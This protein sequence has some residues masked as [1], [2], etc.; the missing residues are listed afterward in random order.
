MRPELRIVRREASI[1]S[2]NV[3]DVCSDN[4]E[5]PYYEDKLGCA[6]GVVFALTFQL[7][8][9][10]ARRSLLEVPSALEPFL[11][12]PANIRAPAMDGTIKQQ[13]SPLLGRFDHLLHNLSIDHPPIVFRNP[14][15]R[16]KTQAAIKLLR[17]RI[18]LRHF[19]TQ[20]AC[21]LLPHLFFPGL[22]QQ[23]AQATAPLLR[24][25]VESDDM[26]CAAS[27][28]LGALKNNEARQLIAGLLRDPAGTL[29][30]GQE[31]LQ[32]GPGVRNLTRKT[33]L[34]ELMQRG[35][36]PHLKTA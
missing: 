36:V 22:H 10:V 1:V 30:M 16:H 7:V 31:V 20:H 3:A 32:F 25:D 4:P 12:V 19:Q 34:V 24:I 2:V 13:D 27:M 5:H 9:V 8:L 14:P 29:G 11:L 18:I 23:G 35:Q 17:G 6:R 28:A 26:T 15:P 21:A 33:D